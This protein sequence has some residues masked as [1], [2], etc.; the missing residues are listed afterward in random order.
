MKEIDLTS[1]LSELKKGNKTG[2]ERATILQEV[3]EKIQQRMDELAAIEAEKS[4]SSDKEYDLNAAGTIT[5]FKGMGLYNQDKDGKDKN[6][7]GKAKLEGERGDDFWLVQNAL[8]IGRI[9][10]KVDGDARRQKRAKSAGEMA[11]LFMGINKIAYDLLLE[12]PMTGYMNEIIFTRVL[13][14]DDL[15][16]KGKLWKDTSQCW[17]CEKWDL[18]KITYS[19][20]DNRIMKQNIDK[21]KELD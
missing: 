2:V 6:G 18:A 1:I 19:E 14:K 7:G 20:T 15:I 11:L 8:K 10:D 17:V 4:D 21:L 13:G 16:W 3:I 12:N 9:K 5:D